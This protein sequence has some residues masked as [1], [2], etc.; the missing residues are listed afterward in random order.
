LRRILREI[1]PQIV[2]LDRGTPL[3]LA[4]SVNPSRR[5]AAMI[6]AAAPYLVAFSAMLLSALCALTIIYTLKH[7]DPKEETRSESADS[8][9]AA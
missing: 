4:R 8:H 1:P 2:S 6:G 9:R 7:F 5:L 3:A